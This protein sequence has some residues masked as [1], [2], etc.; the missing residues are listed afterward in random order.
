ME[1]KEGNKEGRK[2]D[3]CMRGF[4]KELKRPGNE[5]LKLS[6]PRRRMGDPV[7]E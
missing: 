4:E 1:R 5:G 6:L 3:V 7:S 2:E